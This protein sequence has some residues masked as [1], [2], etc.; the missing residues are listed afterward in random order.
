[1]S[2]LTALNNQLLHDRHMSALHFDFEKKEIEIVIEILEDLSGGFIAELVTLHFTGVSGLV[3]GEITQGGEPEIYS[4]DFIE[5]SAALYK[6]S[7]MTLLGKSMPSWEFSFEFTDAS[8]SRH[9]EF[10]QHWV[11]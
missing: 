8:I 6:A 1:M 3:L 5:L 11:P 9:A 7:F 2:I 10:A 4:A